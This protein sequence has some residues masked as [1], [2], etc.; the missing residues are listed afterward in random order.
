MWLRAWL[1]L[2]PLLVSSRAVA[3]LF[4]YLAERRPRR[5]AISWFGEEWRDEVCG[6]A[7]TLFRRVTEILHGSMRAAVRSREVVGDTPGRRMSALPP[8]ASRASDR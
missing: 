8:P 1:R 5:A 7:K 3:A 4:Y 2:R 6:D